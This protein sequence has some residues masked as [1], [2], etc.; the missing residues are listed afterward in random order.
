MKEFEL[1]YGCNPNQKPSKIYMHDGSELPIEILCGRPGYIN[2]LDAQEEIG[3]DW[4]TDTYDAGL[5]LN[6]YGAHKLSAY[7]GKILVEQCGV[8]DHRSD[9]ALQAEWEE[10]RKIYYARL[11]EMITS[12][13]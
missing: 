13:Y 6:I 8:A 3:I 11:Q 1:K 2:L 12:T 5:H 9:A 10:K 4:S 7:F